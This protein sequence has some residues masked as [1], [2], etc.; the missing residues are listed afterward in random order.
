METGTSGVPQD[1]HSGPGTPVQDTNRRGEQDLRGH[2][3][4]GSIAQVPL[5]LGNNSA[6]GER[7]SPGAVVPLTPT[8][9][10]AE[11]ELAAREVQMP[12]PQ[13]E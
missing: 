13:P 6:P 3:G 4:P 8:E 10:S 7:H 1:L 11:E 9:E 12:A 2:R 5:P